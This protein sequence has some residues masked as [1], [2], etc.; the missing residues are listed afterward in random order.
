M[1]D[2]RGKKIINFCFRLVSSRV[3]SHIFNQKEKQINSLLSV[4]KG[5]F[6]TARNSD[7]GFIVK[8]FIKIISEYIIKQY[9]FRCEWCEVN[10]FFFFESGTL[11]ARELGSTVKLL[12]WLGLWATH[13]LL[14]LEKFM[15]VK[16]TIL[17]LDSLSYPRLCMCDMDY[18]YR[19][20]SL[21]G[22]WFNAR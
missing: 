17:T 4:R 6:T 2:V 5:L 9:K 14:H 10:I 8:V 16:N 1:T 11:C 15:F 21:F 22:S 13:T 20:N 7:V 18:F 12:R 19:L 3:K